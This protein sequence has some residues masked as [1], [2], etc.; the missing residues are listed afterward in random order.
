MTYLTAEAR[1]RLLDDMALAIEEL[2]LALAG[3]GGQVGH[4][5]GSRLR[6][7]HHSSP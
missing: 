5:S 1:Q 2:A 3:L 6:V 7:D 4:G